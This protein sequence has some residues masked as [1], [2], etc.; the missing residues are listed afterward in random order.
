MYLS[1][2]RLKENG[3]LNRIKTQE[4]DTIKI[5]ISGSTEIT[6]EI[7]STDTINV[8]LDHIDQKDSRFIYNGMVLNPSLTFNFYGI[9][10]KDTV[11]VLP[12]ETYKPQNIP[13]NHPAPD[14]TKQLQAHFNKYWAH[15]T[16][17]PEAFQRFKDTADPR[18]AHENARLVD[19][20]RSKME[21]NPRQYRAMCTKI[22]NSPHSQPLLSRPKLAADDQMQKSAPFGMR[23]D[24]MVASSGP[25]I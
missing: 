15:R 4:N 3:F 13:E 12:S 11:Y 20:Q 17:D 23:N 14:L 6:A 2:P 18:T 16:A 19:I 24:N 1:F 5:Q 7:S 25:K 22:M 9:T 21:S 10:D 8:L